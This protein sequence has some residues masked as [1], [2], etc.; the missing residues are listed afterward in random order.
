LKI[1]S[2]LLS[3]IAQHRA[4]APIRIAFPNFE[5]NLLHQDPKQIGYT[6]RWLD[7][8]RNTPEPGEAGLCS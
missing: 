4:E 1:T 5:E 3:Q 6:G 2:F 7:A 8:K